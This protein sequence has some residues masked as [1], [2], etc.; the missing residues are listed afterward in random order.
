MANS[1]L[2]LSNEQ[3][4][5]CALEYGVANRVL[6]RC[7]FLA[8]SLHPI[9][10]NSQLMAQSSNETGSVPS[11]LMQACNSLTD[12]DLR[13]RCFSEAFGKL[14][15]YQENKLANNELKRRFAEVFAAIDAGVSFKEYSAIANE[16]AKAISAYKVAS[17]NPNPDAILILER[18]AQ[19]IADAQRL[20]HAQ[21]Y[22]STD[23]GIFMGGRTVLI[24]GSGVADII[25]KYNLVPAGTR[26]VNTESL[27]PVVWGYAKKSMSDGFAILD[28][29]S[30]S[31]RK[32]DNTD[33]LGTL[34]Q[35]KSYD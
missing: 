19:A 21:I 30:E 7:L 25:S 33:G 18:A 13:L 32:L 6:R 34:Y 29:A 20:W 22:K 24:S 2:A 15:N 14:G 10:A 31:T 28:G 8:I 12:A 16:P 23:G 1:I 9:I 3:G 35:R 5:Y 4:C 27:L 17:G 26:W 11:V